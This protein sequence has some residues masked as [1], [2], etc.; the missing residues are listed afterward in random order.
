MYY[1]Y[2]Y[3]DP[4]N[5]KPF[6]IG[7]GSGNRCYKHLSETIKNTTNPHKTRKI[8]SILRDGYTPIIKK[9]KYF[10]NEDDAYDYEYI[11]IEKYG[12]RKNGGILTNYNRCRRYRL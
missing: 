6:Y 1:V 8:Q 2:I 7:K 4:R 11:L 10:D 3:I 9:V 12:R 5:N